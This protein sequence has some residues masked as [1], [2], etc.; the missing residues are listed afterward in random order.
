MPK[1]GDVSRKRLMTCHTDLVKVADKAI[2]IVDFS[3]I[4]GHRGREAQDKA[5]AEGRSKLM[6]PESEH[7]KE[8]SNAFDFV[9]FPFNLADTEAHAE[10]KARLK[11]WM[12][13][14]YTAGVLVGV[15]HGLGIRLRSGMD[16][17][18]NGRVDDENFMD[19]PHLE[20]KK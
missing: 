5:F 7:N 17:N 4:E 10:A 3:L 2:E 1:F 14:A 8:P 16:F 19:A 20:I 13:Y 18:N 15:G 11:A 6:F 9:P 12:Q